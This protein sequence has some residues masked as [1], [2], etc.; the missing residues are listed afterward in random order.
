M[1]ALNEPALYMENRFFR[2]L[3][4]CTQ[5]AFYNTASSSILLEFFFILSP[6]DYDL[7]YNDLPHELK[8]EVLCSG[9]AFGS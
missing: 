5:A 3:S 6:L 7:N 8:S 1:R 2:V 9:R 4:F